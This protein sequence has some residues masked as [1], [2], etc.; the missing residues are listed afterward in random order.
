MNLASL[1][2][3]HQVIYAQQNG[4]AHYTLSLWS[5]DTTAALEHAFANGMRSLHEAVLL[6]HNCAWQAPT[7]PMSFFNIN[8]PQDLQN[9]Q[10]YLRTL[11]AHS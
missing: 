10:A 5:T 4:S 11:D 1:A 7:N 9:A 8:T 2:Q 6:F 3:H